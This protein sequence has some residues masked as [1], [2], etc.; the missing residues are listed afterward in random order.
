[1]HAIRNITLLFA[2]AVLALAVS[3]H[4]A[5][6]AHS[7]LPLVFIVVGFDGG[8]GGQ[9]VPYDNDLDWHE[10]LFGGGDSL[11][12]YYLDMSKGAF[13]FAPC[14]E[15]SAYGEAGNTNAADA[16]ND[17]IVHVTLHGEHGSWGLAAQ[18]R[19]VAHELA[20]AL[21][22]VFDA[23]ADSI[24]FSAYDADGDGLI[25]ETEL[26]VCVCIAG[27]DASAFE[28]PASDEHPCTWPHAGLL[29]EELRSS[30]HRQKALPSNYIAIAEYLW[31]DY[32][33][34]VPAQ[35]E[36]LGIVYHELGH[37]LGL[38]D[39]YAVTTTEGPWEAYEVGGLSLMAA[40][41]WQFQY[42]QADEAVFTPSALDAW[43][44]YVLG[45]ADPIVIAH[46]GD[47]PVSSQLSDAGYSQLVIPTEDPNE[48]YL[49]ENR[50]PEGHDEALTADYDM[51]DGIVIWH[52]DNAMFEQYYLSN[53]MNDADHRPGV[54]VEFT[55]DGALSLYD[56]ADDSPETRT[57]AGITVYAVS[58]PGRD[59]T[60]HVEMDDAAGRRNAAHL[61]YDAPLA[62]LDRQR[63]PARAL[64]HIL[65]V[66]LAIAS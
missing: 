31:Y 10:A 45:W 29:S 14:A 13:T 54:M 5:L 40:G 12:S 50:Q 26:A 17:G 52:V 37:F 48:Y 66:G 30:Q 35:Q 51:G 11:S 43:S 1:M 44:R 63:T 58:E 59:M 34:D 15:T 38:P 39:L 64:S 46:S 23:A 20:E 53:T 21:V 22:Q 27:Y 25:S 65:Q 57:G 18:D 24:D 42:D 28:N 7:E 9:A 8:D 49:V 2:A 16:A 36:P 56:E 60:V 47:Y 61:V 33:P 32:A 6:A 19:Q 3:P 62:Y 4:S 41:A 55:P